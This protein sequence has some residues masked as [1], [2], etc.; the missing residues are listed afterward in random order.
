MLAGGRGR[1]PIGVLWL[2]DYNFRGL[3]RASALGPRAGRTRAPLTRSGSA[4]L[5]WKPSYRP[6]GILMMGG[7]PIFTL[8]GA[9]ERERGKGGV[10]NNR[11]GAGGVEG[12]GKT[13]LR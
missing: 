8:K 6:G 5:M 1:R 9:T 4:T 13:A 11:A 12:P 3:Q 7:Q 10:F 2:F